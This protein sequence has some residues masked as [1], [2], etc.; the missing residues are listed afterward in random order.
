MELAVFIRKEGMA[1]RFALAGYEKNI[2]PYE[3]L[4]P[5]F[6]RFK[7]LNDTESLIRSCGRCSDIGINSP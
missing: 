1:L 4:K 2:V 6:Q 5:A 3:T 7:Q